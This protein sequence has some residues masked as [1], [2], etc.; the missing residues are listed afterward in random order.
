MLFLFSPTK[1][2]LLQGVASFLP[3]MAFAGSGYLPQ[4]GEYP[5]AGLLIGDQVRPSLSMQSNGGYLAWHDNATDG[6]GFGISA[7]RIDS[8]GLGSL[9]VFR[10]NEKG[11]GD[12]QNARV[13]VLKGGGAVFVWQ[14]GSQGS[15][16]IYARF[17]GPN[18]TFTTGDVLVNTEISGQQGDPSVALLADGGLVVTWSRDRKSVV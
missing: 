5:V 12:Q 13:R 1:K 18:G 2:F 8:N 9:G 15:Q 16:D 11:D 7:R 17:V 14:G 4:G 3:L 6:D 10:V